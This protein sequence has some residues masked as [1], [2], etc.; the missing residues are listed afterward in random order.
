MK[1]SLNETIEIENLL[2]QQGD[3]SDRLVTEAKVLSN[4]EFKEKVQW[5]SLAY[6]LVNLYGR[7]KL[8]KEIKV[9][10]NRLFSTSKYQSFQNQIYSIF[11]K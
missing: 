10:E 4:S 8:L 9:I 11:K 5:Q 7:D 1:T 3:T 2:L 6:D